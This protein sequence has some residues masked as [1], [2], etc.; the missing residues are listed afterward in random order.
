MNINELREIENAESDAERAAW[1]ST[2][3]SKLDT[4]DPPE[5]LMRTIDQYRNAYGV[6]HTE[7]TRCVH[8]II[9]EKLGTA[10]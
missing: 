4:Y 8:E 10:R 2:Y 9:W 5:A 1:I 3:M 7:A 6:T